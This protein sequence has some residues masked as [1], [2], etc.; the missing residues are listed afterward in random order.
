MAIELPKEKKSSIII[1]LIFFAQ[2]RDLVGTS[3]TQLSVMPASDEPMI[4]SKSL[5]DPLEIEISVSSLRNFLL[6]CFPA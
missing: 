2:A 1:N 4:I 6:I 5:S 3:R